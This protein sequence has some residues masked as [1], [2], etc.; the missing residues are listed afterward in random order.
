MAPKRISRATIATSPCKSPAYTFALRSR[1]EISGVVISPISNWDAWKSYN[2]FSAATLGR[3]LSARSL[4]VPACCVL[5][6]TSCL[7]LRLIRQPIDFTRQS[8][9]LYF[10]AGIFIGRAVG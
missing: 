10:K 3:P 4:V 7:L 9:A 2:S 6:A 1:S 8:H 5:T